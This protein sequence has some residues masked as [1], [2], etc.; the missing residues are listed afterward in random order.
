MSVLL[1]LHIENVAV[2]KCVDID[3]EKGFTALTGETGAGKS[4]LIDSIGFLLGA[5]GD[6]ELLRTGEE[7]AVV[8]AMFGDLGEDCCRLLAE[9]ELAPDEDGNLLLT[10]TLGADGRTQCKVNGRAVGTYTLRA[11]APSLISIHGQSDNLQL[12]KSENHL[13]ML[14]AYAENKTARDTY[15]AA[16]AAMQDARRA[17]EALQ[18]SDAEKQK[19]T[20]TLTHT[21]QLLESAKLHAGEEEKLLAERKIVADA[22]RISRQTSFVYRALRDAE[23]GNAAYILDR[24]AAALTQIADTVPRAG[25]LA[26]RLG[27]MKYEIEDIADTVYDFTGDIGDDPAARLDRIESRL[28]KLDKLKKKFM[29]DEA[30]LLEKLTAA[31]Q[32]LVALSDL[33]DETARA[34]KTLDEKTAAAVAAAEVLTASRRAAAE[35][36]VPLV[37]GELAFLDMEKVRFLTDIRPA[38]LSATGADAVEFLIS[39]NPGEEPRPIAKIASGGELAR[40]MLALKSVFADSFGVQTVIYDEIDAGVSGKTARKIGIKLKKSAQGTQTICVTHSAQI[41]SLADRQL[42]IQKQVVGT[43]TETQVA[44]ITGED[45]VREIARILGGVTVSETMRSS[46]RELIEE[47]KKY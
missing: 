46:A 24:C 17:L 8:S 15:A 39:A 37:S 4:I 38:A 12:L 16:Y 30:G 36:L 40:I 21:V 42:L 31:K 45:R 32:E 43:R 2:I 19:K 29:T 20:E 13:S 35:R 44:E 18:M 3:F 28:D 27:D 22:E 47:G 1:S 6:R 23:K 11:V 25:E 7:K 26:A 10:R 14:D 9:N 41:A 33:S 34:Q 5:R